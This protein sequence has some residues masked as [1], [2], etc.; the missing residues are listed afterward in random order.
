MDKITAYYSYY[1]FALWSEGL[2]PWRMEL[3]GG[4]LMYK[5]VY[6]I[7]LSNVMLNYKLQILCFPYWFIYYVSLFKPKV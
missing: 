6:E 7:R 4:H 2:D 1:F 5:I 3:F